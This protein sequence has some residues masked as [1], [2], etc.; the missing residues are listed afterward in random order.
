MQPE[1][2]TPTALPIAK[3]LDFLDPESDDSDIL[4]LCVNTPNLSSTNP[5]GLN[6]VTID[7]GVDFYWYLSTMQATTTTIVETEAGIIN[8]LVNVRVRDESRG[9]N[10]ENL[11]FPLGSAF[12]TGERPYR[13]LNPRVVRGN[14][15]LSFGFTAISTAG[16]T[17]NNLFL[18]LHGFTLPAG[19]VAG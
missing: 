15:V 10:L 16:I 12:G 1:A 2:L 9:I 6:S 11:R 5:T 4:F 14:T 19:S 18:V 3:T 13:L 17:Y 8:P 7:A